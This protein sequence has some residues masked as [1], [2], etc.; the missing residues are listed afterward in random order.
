MRD[1]YDRY[2]QPSNA[3]LSLSADIAEEQMLALA[4]EWF[5]D[6]PSTPAPLFTPAT[7]PV[8]SA[9]RRLEVERAVPADQIS[10]AI[11]MEPRT[12]RCHYLCDLLTDLMVGTGNTKF[13]VNRKIQ[14]E[15]RYLTQSFCDY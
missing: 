4:E 15:L 5:G 14:K 13:V 7:E 10:I 12:S 3:I 11:R 8:Q 1:F 9:P 6:I 2:Y